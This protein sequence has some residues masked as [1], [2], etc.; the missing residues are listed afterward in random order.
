MLSLV[1]GFVVVVLCMWYSIDHT[2][3]CQYGHKWKE[4]RHHL[5]CEECGVKLR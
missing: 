1:V 2:I 4:D 3:P 5:W